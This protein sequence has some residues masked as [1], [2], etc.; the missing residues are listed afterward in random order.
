MSCSD[1]H[2]NL[3]KAAREQATTA[4]TFGILPDDLHLELRGLW[5]EFEAGAT[6]EARFAN[7]LD[8]LQPLLHN[9]HT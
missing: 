8:R 3:D 7:A 1:A 6:L 9:F 4:H 2:I 5:E